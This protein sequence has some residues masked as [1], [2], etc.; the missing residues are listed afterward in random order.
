[1]KVVVSQ[2]ISD[3]TKEMLESLQGAAKD[4]LSTKEKL[5]QY[6]VLWDGEKPVLKGEDAPNR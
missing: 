2:Q 4:A 6:S 5:G 1:M 3:K